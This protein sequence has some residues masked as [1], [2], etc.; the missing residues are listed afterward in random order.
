MKTEVYQDLHRSV[1][2][3][4]VNSG[5]SENGCV[6][7]K[8]IQDT[9][10][11]CP[12]DA[13]WFPGADALHITLMDWFAPLV[14]YELPHEELF[15]KHKDEYVTALKKILENQNVITVSFDTIHVTPAA[16]I[17]IG[18]DD[19]SYANLRETFLKHTSLVPGT[20]MPPKRI[21]TSIARFKK[22]IPLEAVEKCL[23]ET[24]VHFRETVKEFRLVREREIPLLTFDVVESFQL[25]GKNA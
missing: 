3:F 18:T 7:I 24:K 2:G 25:T 23:A 10:T 14:Q 16:V 4:V 5:F 17:L 21:H 15:Q 20:K 13:V 8:L 11:R 22:E 19:G 6:E 9:L 12:G 1:T